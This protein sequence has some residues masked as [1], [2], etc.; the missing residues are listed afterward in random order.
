MSHAGRA[1]AGF[2]EPVIEPRGG[3]VAQVGA[4]RLVDGAEHLQQ[5]EDDADKRQR[6][7]ERVPALHGADQHAHG[8]RKRSRQDAA[9]QQHRPPAGG[10]AGSAFGRTLKNFHSL[11]AVNDCSMA[12]VSVTVGPG[13]LHL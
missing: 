12:A 9:Q 2:G 7:G 8:D 6:A 5:D 13:K 3:A 4:E 10:Q 11:R 1:H